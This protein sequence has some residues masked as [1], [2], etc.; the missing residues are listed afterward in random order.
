MEASVPIS[1]NITPPHLACPEFTGAILRAISGS[2]VTVEILET[3]PV[4]TESLAGIRELKAHGV[5]FALDDFGTGFSDW[6]QVE[7]VR[8]NKLKFDRS[9]LNG[10]AKALLGAIRRAQD[11]G[12]KTVVE[13]VEH[14][15][16]FEMAQDA[17][18]NAVQGFRFSRSLP[19]NDFNAFVERQSLN[20]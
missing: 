20:A 19:L 17:G 18:A 7:L 3:H 4:T 16:Q 15:W 8:P 12:M 14:L 11:M 10:P 9:W 2:R 1:F 13:G 6:T 5:E